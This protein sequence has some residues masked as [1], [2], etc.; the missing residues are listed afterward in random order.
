MFR[1]KPPEWEK[2]FRL[3]GR[4]GISKGALTLFFWLW[5]LVGLLFNCG[6][7]FGIAGIVEVEKSTHLTAT[8]LIWIG[9]MLLFGIGALLSRSDFDGERPL[10]DDYGDV[11]TRE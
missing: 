1:R 5:G 3:R 7:L 4:C 8:C 11:R 2:T 9:G 6:T 10:A